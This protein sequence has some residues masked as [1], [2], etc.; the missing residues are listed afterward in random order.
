[1]HSLVLHVGTDFEAIAWPIVTAFFLIVQDRYM[2][3][4]ASASVFITTSSILL[5]ANDLLIRNII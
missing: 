3:L 5:L 4:Q 1:M 2:Q